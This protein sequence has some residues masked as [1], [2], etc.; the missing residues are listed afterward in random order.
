[1][2]TFD[3]AASLDRWTATVSNGQD[4]FDRP[5]RWSGDH[6]RSC[7]SPA[8]SRTIEW[9]DINDD[10]PDV[11]PAGDALYWC[12]PGNPN[13][14]HVMTAFHTKGYSHLDFTPNRTFADVSRVCWDVNATNLGNRKWHQLAVVPA[15]V[16]AAVAPRLD[17]THP[18]FRDANGPASWGLGL[19]GGVFLY[20]STQGNSETFTDGLASGNSF[21]SDTSSADKAARYTTCVADN[22]NNTVTVSQD[23]PD[24]ST[25]VHR[26]P[27]RFP[28]GEVK[29]VFQDVSY[30]PD[31]AES[32]PRV[33]GRTWHWDNIVIE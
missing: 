5:T 15:D 27:G 33:A 20:S 16:A 22:G 21:D 13:N 1:V 2:E 6:D 29:V 17:W 3:T 30:N 26:L 10:L 8:T 18:A 25:A 11:R 31:K 28:Q 14:G 4:F 7:G 23:R 24:G 12:S 32:P 19:S 9:P